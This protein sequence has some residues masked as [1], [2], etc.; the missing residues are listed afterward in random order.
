MLTKFFINAA[1]NNSLYFIETSN[2]SMY[3]AQNYADM[4]KCVVLI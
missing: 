4:E 1:F 2:S 3:R